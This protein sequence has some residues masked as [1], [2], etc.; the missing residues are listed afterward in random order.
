MDNLIKSDILK[1][2]ILRKYKEKEISYTASYLSSFF[3]FK[4]ETVKKAL[5]FFCFIGVLEK[6]IKEHGKN[7]YTYYNLTKTGKELLKSDNL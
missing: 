1:V 7:D 2:L 4:Y 3:E 6:D 5:E